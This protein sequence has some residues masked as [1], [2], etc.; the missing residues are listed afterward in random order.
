MEGIFNDELLIYR[1]SDIFVKEGITIRQPTLGE[2]CDYG[3]RDYFSMVFSLTAVP[4]DLKW[5]L[6]ELG[7]DYTHVSDFELFYTMLYKSFTKEQTAIL[8][9]GLDWAG[10]GLYSKPDSNDVVLFNPCSNIIID[11]FTYLVIMDV[12][13]RIHGLK[14]NQQL[15]GNEATKRILIEDARD[16]YFASLDKEYHS[17]LKHLISTMINSPGFKYGHS[18]VWNMKINAFMDSVKRISK[19]KHADL[20]LQSGYSGYGINLKDVTS[21]QLDW[22]GEL[23]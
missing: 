23:D 2:I 4:A 22:L 18:E 21:Q 16:A 1:G 20:L 13:R 8:F 7:L 19:I 15:P 3:E 12:L 10:F 9:G 17:Q 11:E 5:Q 6:D 14:R